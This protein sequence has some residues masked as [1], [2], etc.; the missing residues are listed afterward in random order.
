M[1]VKGKNYA[2]PKAVNTDNMQYIFDTASQMIGLP[3]GNTWDEQ[4]ADYYFFDKV[5]QTILKDKK[6]E[7]VCF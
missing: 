7:N 4:A 5:I 2:L 3:G 1:Q 6:Y